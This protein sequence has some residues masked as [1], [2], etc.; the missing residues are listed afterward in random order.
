MEAGGSFTQHTDDSTRFRI[1]PLWRII[2]KH[3]ANNLFQS[4]CQVGHQSFVSVDLQHVYLGFPFT[5]NLIKFQ[6][7]NVQLNNGF[8]NSLHSIRAHLLIK[9]SCANSVVLVQ[10]SVALDVDSGNYIIVFTNQIIQFRTEY[11]V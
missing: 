11:F 2:R 3:L 10:A 6:K 5:I 7:Y 4:I 1:S 9:R 8:L